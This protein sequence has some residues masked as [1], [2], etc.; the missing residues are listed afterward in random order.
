ME[1]P[2]DSAILL[3]GLYPKHSK[4]ITQKYICTPMFTAALFK[5]AEAQNKP[6]CPSV[7]EWIKKAVVHLHNE[8]PLG[9]K[10]EGNLAFCNSIN[11]SGVYYA[12]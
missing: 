4:T 3:L 5:I 9:C 10:K 12:E 2:F 8:I 11:G 6:S 7:D 1:L